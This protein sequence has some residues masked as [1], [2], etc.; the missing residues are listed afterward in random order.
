MGRV[1]LRKTFTGGSQAEKEKRKRQGKVWFEVKSRLGLMPG[2][3]FGP[4]PAL[5]S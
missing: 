2:G 1:F 4:L 3:G 5:K